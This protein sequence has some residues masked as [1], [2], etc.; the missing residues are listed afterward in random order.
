[1]QIRRFSAATK[2]YSI[3]ITDI[4]RFQK[5]KANSVKI[6]CMHKLFFSSGM[7]NVFQKTK[8]N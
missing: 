5:A 8:T 1:M 7:C 3:F 4:N 6:F 2:L